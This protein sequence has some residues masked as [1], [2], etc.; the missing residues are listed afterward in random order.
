MVH[1]PHW[2]EAKAARGEEAEAG[3]QGW[4]ANQATEATVLFIAKARSLTNKTDERRLQTS[5]NKSVKD[6]WILVITETWLRPSTLDSAVEL[7][8]YMA[9]RH[10]RTENSS[11]SK[12]G[13]GVLCL[14]V[15]NNWF[16]NTEI[17]EPGVC[18]C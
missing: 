2:E 6:C 16:T 14:Y 12:G 3:L 5:A 1:R 8:G 15:N 17:V 10:D 11:K 9:Q 4:R 18:D 7:T 13:G